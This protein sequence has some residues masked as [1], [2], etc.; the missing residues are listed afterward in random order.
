MAEISLEKRLPVNMEAE[1]YLLG[2]MLL[3]CAMPADAKPGDFYLEAHRKIFNCM[4]ELFEKGEDVNLFV[5]KNRLQACSE[6]ETVGGV[7]YLVGLTD[8]IPRM[9]MAPQYIREI[10]NMAAL[11]RLIQMGADTMARGYQAEEAPRD[12]TTSV[13]DACDEV[14]SMLQEDEGLKPIADLVGPAF[15]Q[16]EARAN[17]Q[18]S[19]AYPTGYTD[20]DRMLSGGLRPTNQTL[21]AGRPGSGKTAFATNV[22]LNISKTEPVAFFSLEMGA[23][24]LIERMIASEAEVD[25]CRLNT[26]FLNKQDWGRI[27]KAAGDICNLKLWIDDSTG[28]SVSDMRSRIRRIRAGIKVCVV[29]YL[30]LLNPPERLRKAANEYEQVGAISKSLKFMAKSM[31]IAMVSLSQLSRAPEKRRDPKPQLSD[32]RSSGN[33][34]Q[35]ADNVLFVYREELASPTDENSG[36]ADIIVGKQRNGPIGEVKLGYVKQFTKFTNLYQEDG[37]R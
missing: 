18:S 6:L 27:C 19:G 20:L 33:L 31:N 29:D 14:N 21:I 34:E 7:A 36:L 4:S 24:E 23:G 3:D 5:V 12:I 17:R 11:R 30:Q 28:I 2:A 26:G 37:G 35:D 8:G 15:K 32:L 10:R 13:L 22:A 16:I 1:R 25:L 9:D